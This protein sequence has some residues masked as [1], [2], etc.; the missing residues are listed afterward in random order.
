MAARADKHLLQF[1]WLQAA[2]KSNIMSAFHYSW[3]LADRTGTLRQEQVIVP[4]T[5]VLGI[6]NRVLT[7][8]WLQR[9]S[10]QLCFITI[11]TWGVYPFAWVLFSKNHWLTLHY[12]VTIRLLIQIWIN[13]WTLSIDLK[14]FLIWGNAEQ[15]VMWETST[16]W[17]LV[18]WD[19]GP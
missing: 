19:N 1:D 2:G 3:G 5:E 4:S 16:C 13:K 6:I 12:S 15:G 10:I 17:E 14:L 11:D 8:F 9:K 7:R 18:A